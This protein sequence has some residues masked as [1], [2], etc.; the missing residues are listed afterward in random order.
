MASL[1][2]VSL[3]VRSNIQ[4]L[5]SKRCSLEEDDAIRNTLERANVKAEDI[6]L[7]PTNETEI[8]NDKSS[9]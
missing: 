6:E 4:L 1:S 8:R 9:K 5:E 7:P 2:T 3:D